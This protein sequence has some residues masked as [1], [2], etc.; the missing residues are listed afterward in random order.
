MYR[1][2]LFSLVLMALGFATTATAQETLTVY[3]GQGQSN[4][5]PAY[6]FYWDDFTRSQVVFPAADLKVM[7]EG[8]ITALTFY[9]DQTL[10]YTSVSTCH[11]Y[12][13]EVNYTE[14]T[15]FEP[16]GTVLYYGTLTV[17]A[18]GTLTIELD[19]PYKYNGGNLLLGIENTTDSGYKNVKFYGQ[20][21]H[22]GA[23]FAGYNS[24]STDAV[25]GSVRDFIPKTTFT[26]VPSGGVLV[27]K[28]INLA[29]S[30][31]TT[32]GAT[33]TWAA[34]AEETSWNF[35]YK[36]KADEAWTSQVVT[37]PS[38]TLDALQN[39]CEYNVRVNAIAGEN[40]SVWVTANFATPTCDDADKGEISYSLIDSYGDGWSGNALEFYNSNGVLEASVTL[41]SGASAEG[42]V[43]LCYGETYTIKWK[44]GSYGSECGFVVYGPD[45]NELVNHATGTAPT[46]GE[47][48]A[49]FLMAVPS[50]FTPQDLTVGEVTYN[51]AALSWTPGDAEQDAWQVA[52]G[53]KGFNPDQ[54][55]YVYTDVTGEPSVV[56]EGLTENTAYD[57]YVRGNCGEGDV[58][59][60]SKVATFT[61][62]LQ[63]PLPT[64]LAV[65][66]IT[67]KS[68]RASWTGTTESYNLRYREKSD[69][70]ESF[71]AAT[72]PDG[73]N[74]NTWQ[75]M[76][77]SQY[78]M[79]GTALFAADGESCISSK[80][81][82]DSSSALTPLNVDNWL[83][84]PKVDLAG[85]L[86]FYVADLGANYIENYGVYVSTTGTATADFTALE[87]N[88]ATQGLM[89]SAVDNWQKKEFDLSAY[90]GQKGYIAI[91]HHDAQGYY[92]LIDAVKIAGEDVGAEWITVENTTAPVT[93]EPLAP[94]T[95][96]E[97]QVQGI[98]DEGISGWTESVN[99]TTKPADAMPINLA[100]SDITA[101]T[102]DANWEG[103][104]DA[105]NLRYRTAGIIGSY[106]EGFEY[107]LESGA[108]PT[109]SGWTTIDADGDGYAWYTFSPDN[110][111]DN[112]GNPAVL[113]ASCMT[114]ASYMGGAL[115][116]DDWLI[117]PALDLGGTL[118][119]MVRGQD[120]SYA[121]EHYAVYVSTG[122][123]TNVTSFVELIPEAVSGGVYEEI[124][125]DLS[126]Y[127]G[128]KG[129]IA[130]RHFNCTDQFRLN[131]DNFRIIND[132]ETVEP[133]EWVVVENVTPIYTIEGLTPE[134]NYEV[135]VQGIV[136][137]QNTTEWTRSV[138][139]T[140]LEAEDEGISE[141]YL[142]GSFNGW[143]WESE[144]GRLAMT[145]D[146]G[147]YAVTLDLASGD[148]FKIITPNEE[149]PT[150]YTWFGGVDENQ[151]GYFLVTEELLNA[152]I[153][154]TQ[155]SNF[156]M[157]DAGNY[158][159][160]IK[161]APITF[162][163]IKAPFVMEVVKNPVTAISDINA[164]KV[165]DKNWYNIHGMKL[166]GVPTE[167]G[168]YF[169]GGKKV[170]VK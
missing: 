34:G 118:S 151:V 87:D 21:G 168:I 124:T 26:Y 63:F 64:S 167:P 20:T 38:V 31:I 29:V 30:N 153:T 123:P 22:S 33:V 55:N 102:A 62:P 68:A 41:T 84:S 85:A 77:I 135:Q 46:A 88:I 65:T 121:A 149:D 122:D 163:G 15:A 132:A 100:V 154:L 10:E 160:T 3:D 8:T 73:W 14:M 61:T 50:C 9:T 42:T 144:E 71:E 146:D 127:A 145:E 162:N 74:I 166:Q 96:Y 112:N 90:A 137:E 18:D 111:V 147:G 48:L 165:A 101:T 161:E 19:T 39:G 44:A 37:T 83:I 51:T 58:S 28:P 81:M 156:R 2:L 86:E 106:E 139:F 6:I 141:F 89:P 125:A 11:V 36:K 119:F 13:M 60:W 40:T 133:G 12:L 23:S 52:V 82:D 80:S 94:S 27:P 148:E 57:A 1:K 130:I 79:A 136:D 129:Y 78:N 72:A 164:G 98:Y 92:L 169:N 59:A 108:F 16:K 93:M 66:D 126:A 159:I 152:G 70:D 109:E 158:T 157:A 103:S 45:G 91:R 69:L 35:E 43:A 131:I 110:T 5:V 142:V 150:G 7:K 97:C 49:E 134:T 138:F 99:F 4:V 120:P 116:P 53:A 115:T 170:V 143:N 140:T 95:T 107:G 56:I 25:T 128:Q 75:L 54:E 76:P 17:R 117:S 113:D 105:Y 104:Q 24:G 32:N 47:T 155:G 67:A 114:S